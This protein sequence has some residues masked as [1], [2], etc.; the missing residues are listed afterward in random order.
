ME[1]TKLT[2]TLTT[3]TMIDLCVISYSDMGAIP[4]QVEAMGLT[5]AWGPA[6]GTG[7]FGVP[8]SAM[9][10]AQDP[11]TGSYIVTIRGTQYDSIWSW[12]FEDFDVYFT[13]PFNT[14]APAAPDDAYISNATYNGLQALF[15]LTDPNTGVSMIDFLTSQVTDGSTVYVTGHSLGGTLTFPMGAY[16]QGQLGMANITQ[17]S[18]CCNG[19][20]GLTPGNGSCADFI[21]GQLSSDSIR[22]YNPLDIAPLLFNQQSALQNIYDPTYPWD[23][24]DFLLRGMIDGLYDS[25][26]GNGY[27]QPNGPGTSLPYDFNAQGD[28]RLEAEY[29][30]HSTTY[31]TLVGQM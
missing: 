4:A 31:Q 10:V 26:S 30:H 5:T 8:Y 28:W 13:T 3:Q 25:A 9:F 1:P 20:A 23:N 15:S 7:L 14:V 21:N 6:D 11:A 27:T 2:T 29:Q 17:T 18:V 12:L 19:F 16:I 22:F 24:L